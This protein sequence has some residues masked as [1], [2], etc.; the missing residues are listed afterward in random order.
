MKL[1]ESHFN[2]IFIDEAGQ[3]TQ[4][5]SLIPIGLTSSEDQGHIG[6]C[7]AQIVLSGDPQQL[8]PVIMTKIGQHLLGKY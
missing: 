1:W 8:G 2:Y 4:P 5:E 3:A 7:H 6:K